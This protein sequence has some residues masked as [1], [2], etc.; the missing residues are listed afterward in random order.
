M[1]TNSIMTCAPCLS[2]AGTHTRCIGMPN[3]CGCL[4]TQCRGNVAKIVPSVID[5]KQPQYYTRGKI[6]VWD[7]IIDQDLG[8]I[9]GNAVKYICRAGFKDPAKHIEDLEKAKVY[10]DKEIS[11]L[12]KAHNTQALKEID[13]APSKP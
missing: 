12:K 5:I 13:H 10:I 8:F 1:I 2:D 4:Q 7:F 11:E 9:L 6:E 3:G